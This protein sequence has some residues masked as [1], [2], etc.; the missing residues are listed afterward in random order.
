MLQYGFIITRKGVCIEA[1]PV[2]NNW[3]ARFAPVDPK[4]TARPRSALETY[5]AEY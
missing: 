4:L 3:A 1:A 2:E 5:I